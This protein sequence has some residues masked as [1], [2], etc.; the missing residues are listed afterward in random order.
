MKILMFNSPSIYEVIDNYLDIIMNDT[1]AR[2][3]LL[4]RMKAISYIRG[5]RL[6]PEVMRAKEIDEDAKAQLLYTCITT[7]NEGVLSPSAIVSFVNML[8]PNDK[9]AGLCLTLA[10]RKATTDEEK[11]AI[12]TCIANINRG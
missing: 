7:D 2:N 11:A 4:G 1:P 12:D 6:L 9:Y 3:I 8:D 5:S 10:A